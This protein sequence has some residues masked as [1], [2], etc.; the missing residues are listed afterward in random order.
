MIRKA[1]E[2]V[3]DNFIIKNDIADNYKLIINV[4]SGDYYFFIT[5]DKIEYHYCYTKDFILFGYGLTNR[6]NTKILTK[7]P[8]IASYL[9]GLVND[10]I[11]EVKTNEK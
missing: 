11:N 4:I 7:K 8:I 1:L 9:M 6:D 5:I 2:N 3:L 10:A